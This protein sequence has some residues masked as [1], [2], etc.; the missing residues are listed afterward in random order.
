MDAYGRPLY[1]GNPF[2]PP[3]S[4]KKKDIPDGG[5]I[6]SDGKTIA[7]AD[8]GALPIGAV[9]QE[10]ESEAEESDSEMEESEEELEEEEEEVPSADGIESV[11]PPPPS[12]PIATA[13]MDLRKQAGDETPVPG[14]QPKQLYQ[15][16]EQKAASIEQQKGTVFASEVAYAVPG[17][18]VP[19]GAESVLSKMLPPSKA[20]RKEN[21]EDEDALGKNFKF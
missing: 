4:D 6:T 21:D 14:S 19:E 10:E 2:D 13:P 5:L 12:V 11:L 1:G 8:W 20:K 15:V 18:K 9:A 7:R 16:L 3:G 17:T